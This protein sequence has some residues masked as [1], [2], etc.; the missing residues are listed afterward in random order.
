MNDGRLLVVCKDDSTLEVIDL[1]TSKQAG[2]V[3]ASGFSPHEVVATDDGRLA[4]LPVYSDAP[5]GSP[6][7][8][9]QRIDLVDLLRFERVGEIPLAFP[10]RPHQSSLLSTDGILVSTELDESVTVI[11][12]RTLRVVARLPT[13]QAESHM[14][15]VSVDG[16]RLVTANVGPG[17]VSI[18]DV[19][20]R[21]LVGVVDVAEKVNRICLEP[22]GRF[23]YT[24]DQGSPRIAIIDTELIQHVGWIEL[25]SIG[26]GT[27]VT[28]SGSH[29][30]VALRSASEIAVVD[31]R[32]GEVVHRIATPNHPQAVVLHPDGIRAYSACDADN[33]VVEVDIRA[34]R[35]LRRIETGRKPDGIAWSPLPFS[36]SLSTSTGTS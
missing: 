17:S 12:R 22:D 18:I 32:S 6:G 15:A 10:S 24:A 19:P 20:S 26:F 30:V 28:A 2:A 36:A 16:T 34:G 3:T 29:L 14:F 27:A 13:G 25:P 33:C 23:A 8:D 9:G 7:S 11:D 4:Y 35:L 21:T 1:E 31:R 5:V